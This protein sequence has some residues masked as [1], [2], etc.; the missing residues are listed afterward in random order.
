MALRQRIYLGMQIEAP[1]EVGSLRTEVAQ[2]QMQLAATT[3]QLEAANAAA[4]AERSAIH[5]PLPS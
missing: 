2:L 5:P 1:E 4:E 3:E